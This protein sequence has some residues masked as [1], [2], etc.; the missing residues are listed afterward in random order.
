MYTSASL[1]PPHGPVNVAWTLLECQSPLMYG[2][3]MNSA[4][5]IISSAGAQVAEPDGRTQPEDVEPPDGD[6][7]RRSR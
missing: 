4:S 6:D 7:R 2:P 5:G 3:T 1:I